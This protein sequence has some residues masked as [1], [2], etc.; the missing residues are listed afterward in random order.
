MIKSQNVFQNN[1]QNNI[2]NKL[3]SMNDINN[4]NNINNQANINE[5]LNR[6]S[7]NNMFVNNY[8][9]NTQ[10]RLQDHDNQMKIININNNNHDRDY[11][12][13]ELKDY[14]KHPSSNFNSEA[15]T[16]SLN[17][18]LDDNE[19]M[20]Y[21]TYFFNDII[22]CRS[23]FALHMKAVSKIISFENLREVN[24]E[25]ILKKNLGL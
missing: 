24:Y 22:C 9:N 17:I 16:K 5:G 11:S 8:V 2:N 21:L 13:I 15:R 1:S 3:I 10:K 18:E 19:K 12:K 6:N 20:S 14:S 25:Y 23:R 4:I 7:K